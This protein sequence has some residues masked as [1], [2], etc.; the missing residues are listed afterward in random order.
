[1]LCFSSLTYYALP[2]LPVGHTIPHWLTIELGIFAGRLYMGFEECAPLVEYMENDINRK[3]LDA[4][5]TKAI[6][7]LLEWLSLCRKG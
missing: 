6:S 3:R 2:A 4:L 7:F 5:A 1:M